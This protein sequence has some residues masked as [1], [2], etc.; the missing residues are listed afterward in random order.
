MAS[1]GRQSCSPTLG[2]LL[3]ERAALV[4]A[5]AVAID[6]T[7]VIANTTAYQSHGGYDRGSKAQD[8]R[9]AQ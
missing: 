2:L 1:G 4:K 6:G 9:Q 7:K 5:V 8:G 3:C